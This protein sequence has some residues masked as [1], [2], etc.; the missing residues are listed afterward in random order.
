MDAHVLVSVELYGEVFVLLLEFGFFVLHEF[1]HFVHFLALAEVKEDE[2][3]DA[4]EQDND[5]GYNDFFVHNCLVF[6]IAGA[7]LVFFFE[8]CKCLVGYCR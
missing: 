3:C 7:K 8:M 4:E 6:A 5:D 2:C 1:H